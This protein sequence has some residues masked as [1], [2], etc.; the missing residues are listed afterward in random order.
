MS[1]PTAGV[2]PLLLAATVCGAAFAQGESRCTGAAPDSLLLRTGPVYRD[3]EVDQPAKRRGKD[4]S[5][6]F[7]LSRVRTELTCLRVSLEFVVDT[8]GKPEPATVRVVSSD[9]RDLEA[10][11]LGSLPRLQYVPARRAGYPARQIVSYTRA[12]AI[13]GRVAFTVGRID[14][15]GALP[16]SGGRP[17]VRGC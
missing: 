13:P 9:H 6:D 4:P 10:A 17:P 8:L 16:P 14:R 2:L 3:C 15:A 12:V 1:P 5:L 11:V 7:D